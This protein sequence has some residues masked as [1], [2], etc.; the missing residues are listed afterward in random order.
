MR[1]TATSTH[2]EKDNVI[3]IFLCFSN[4]HTDLLSDLFNLNMLHLVTYFAAVML[5]Q[6][7]V[8]MCKTSF[9]PISPLAVNLV[10]TFH[11]YTNDLTSVVRKLCPQRQWWHVAC[12]TYVPL[13][14]LQVILE[15]ILRVRCHSSEG[16]TC[17]RTVDEWSCI[18]HDHVTWIT[19]VVVCV[20]KATE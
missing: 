8:F 6:G 20:H 14:S 9:S 7:T 12:H 13:D 19:D 4:N 15:T 3:L 2:A 10:T 16:W 1:Q 17:P 11:H 5:I 18:S